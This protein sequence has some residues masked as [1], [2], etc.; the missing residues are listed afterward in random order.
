MWFGW[1][2]F[3]ITMGGLFSREYLLRRLELGKQYVVTA[4]AKGAPGTRVI[5]RHVFKVAINPILSTIGWLL[6]GD[7]HRPHAH[8]ERQVP[9]ERP[10]AC[11]TRWA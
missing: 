11:S 4:R 1:S 9:G 10:T 6:R 7:E 5:T 2:W 8:P 3:G